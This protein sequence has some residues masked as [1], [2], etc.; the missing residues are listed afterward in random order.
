MSIFSRILVGTDGSEAAEQAVDFAAR[1]AHEHGTELIIAHSR[2]NDVIERATN[3]AQA[4][5]VAALGRPVD[6]EPARGILDLAQA[7]ASTLIVLAT[8]GSGSEQ[9]VI[10][11]TTEAV[12]RGSTIPVLTVRAGGLARSGRCFERIIVGMDDSEPSDAA[13]ATVIDFPP[14][15]RGCVDLIGVAGTAFVIGGSEYHQAAIDELHED[16]ERILDAALATARKRGRSFNGRVLDGR[17]AQALIAAAQAE[18]ADLIVLGSHGR[19]GLRRLF[20]GSVAESVVQASPIPV[21]VVRG[22]PKA[23][24]PVTESVHGLA[25]VSA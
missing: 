13:L 22:L 10:G 8:H 4:A 1:L 17:P 24:V 18:R 9:T 7:Q 20:V 2:G 15:D 25:M 14:E 21:L 5:G 19:R 12:L 11:A 3:R 6:G 23:T 16:T